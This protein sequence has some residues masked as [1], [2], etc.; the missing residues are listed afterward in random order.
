MLLDRAASGHD[1]G[2]VPAPFA[3][4]KFHRDSE[5]CPGPP[6]AGLTINL[7][8]RGP[9]RANEPEESHLVTGGSAL[10]AWHDDSEL[11]RDAV[12]ALD[13]AEQ[14]FETGVDGGHVFLCSLSL[15]ADEGQLSKARWGAIA[16][17]F[18]TEMD[19]TEDPKERSNVARA[20]LPPV[21]FCRSGRLRLRVFRAFRNRQHPGP[22]ARARTTT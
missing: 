18:M 21:V 22:F 1:D 7:G 12:D 13:R 2:A 8:A 5:H 14:F 19:F 3:G 15:D 17:D 10:M 4:R 11:N 6:Q 20:A 16:D 9:G